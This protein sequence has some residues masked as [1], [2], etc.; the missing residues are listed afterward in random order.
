[1]T[2]IWG[3]ERGEVLREGI[4]DSGVHVSSDISTLMETGHSLSLFF[5]QYVGDTCVFLPVDL[6]PDQPGKSFWESHKAILHGLQSKFL[7]FR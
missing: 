3:K 2:E 5:V 7:A 6:G 4:S 1:M